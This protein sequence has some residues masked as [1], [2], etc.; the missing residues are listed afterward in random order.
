[1]FGT[2]YNWLVSLDSRAPD[3]TPTARVTG[4]GLL[5]LCVA[6]FCFLCIA[7]LAG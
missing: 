3:G 4:G 6:V 2:E 1:M 7:L 5:T